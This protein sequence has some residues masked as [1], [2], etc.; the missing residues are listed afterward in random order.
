MALNRGKQFEKKFSL[1]LKATVPGI[2]INRIYDTVSGYKSV[3]NTSDFICYLY[4]NMFYLECKSCK[5]NTFPFSNLHQYDKLKL[6]VGIKGVRAGAVIWFREHN[7]L[8]YVPIKTFTKMM[9]DGK[10]SINV[11]KSIEEG[12]RIIDVPS[13]I[14]RVF[15]DSDYSFL[16]SLEEG[17]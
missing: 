13:K 8:F 1:D 6:K 10:K 5:G 9:E 7:K 16:T 4:P 3:S 12:Y 11:N 15:L 17:D 14:K 2:D